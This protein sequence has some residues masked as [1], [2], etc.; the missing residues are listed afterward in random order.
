VHESGDRYNTP[1]APSGAYGMLFSTWA[2]FGYSGWP[3]QYSVT[4]QNAEALYLYNEFG[5]QP[6]STKTVCGL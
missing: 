6:W 4:V 3:Y 5:W 1:T 2:S